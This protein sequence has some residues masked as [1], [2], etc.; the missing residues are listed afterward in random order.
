MR[1]L[2]FCDFYELH[3]RRHRFTVL[4]GGYH[5]GRVMMIGLEVDGLPGTQHLLIAGD[6]P[7]VRFFLLVRRTADAAYVDTVHGVCMKPRFVEVLRPADLVQACRSDCAMTTPNFDRAGVLRQRSPW[8]GMDTPPGTLYVVPS[9]LNG[10]WLAVT[11]VNLRK[12]RLT[13]RFLA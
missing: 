1:R 7:S 10:Q 4:P 2:P 3:Q 12:R 9:R 5:D 11:G 13:W 6:V 8:A